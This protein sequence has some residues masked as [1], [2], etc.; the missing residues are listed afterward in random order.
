MLVNGKWT[1][2]W[3]PVQAKDKN[4]GFVRQV[5]SIRN[6]VTPDCSAAPT[7]EGGFEAE[8]DR[9]HLYVAYIAL[10]LESIAPTKIVPPGL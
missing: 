9:Y 10:G 5:A 6:G 7:G 4:G 3:G 2:D 8:P 1:E